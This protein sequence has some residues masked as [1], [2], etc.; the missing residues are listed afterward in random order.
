[1]IEE[2][3]RQLEEL[4]EPFRNAGRA[5]TASAYMRNRF[6]FI[7]MKTEIRRSAQKSWINSLDRKSTR[8]N[9]SHRT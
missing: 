9:S 2:T 1:M 8:L 6:P 5:Q 7:G 3:I 4:F